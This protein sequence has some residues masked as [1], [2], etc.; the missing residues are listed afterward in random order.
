MPHELEIRCGGWLGAGIRE[1]YAYYADVCFRAFGDRV[2]FWT[3]FDEPNLFTKFQNMLGAYPPNH[4]SPPFGS[5]NSGNSNREPY[6]AAHN[7]ILSHAAAVR[8]YKENY[9]QCKAARS[10]L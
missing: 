3:T 9:Q 5:R 10:G 6:V 2:K 8:N 7:I 1:E 4:C